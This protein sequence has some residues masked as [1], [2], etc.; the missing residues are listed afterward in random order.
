MPGLLGGFPGDDGRAPPP[1]ELAEWSRCRD[2]GGEGGIKDEPGRAA[3]ASLR[4]IIESAAA[5]P[6][7][8]ID[9][10]GDGTLSPLDKDSD[11]P[12]KLT[13]SCS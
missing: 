6:P 10:G 7:S 12:G 4:L 11:D 13:K 8:W 5:K 2:L 1:N 9:R 3:A